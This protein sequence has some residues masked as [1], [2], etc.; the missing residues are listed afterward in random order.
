MQKCGDGEVR[1][2]K[3]NLQVDRMRVRREAKSQVVLK[4]VGRNRVSEEQQQGR[5]ANNGAVLK[6]CSVLKF[7]TN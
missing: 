3:T 5:V 1:I 2:D 4:S 6:D 7:G